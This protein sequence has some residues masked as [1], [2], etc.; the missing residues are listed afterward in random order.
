MREILFRAKML[1]KNIW[2]KGDLIRDYETK[3]YSIKPIKE[4]A[5]HY[6]VVQE[7][8]GQFTGLKDKN[9]KRIYEGDILKGDHSHATVV[10]R[11]YEEHSAFML[12]CKSRNKV[13]FLYDNDYTTI[14]NIGNI[15][16]NPELMEG[17]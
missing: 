14:E 3:T 16:D 6:P 1:D 7:T 8:I 13:Y 15:H 10:V 5:A 4:V 12:Y 11:W 17:V 2:V 9:G